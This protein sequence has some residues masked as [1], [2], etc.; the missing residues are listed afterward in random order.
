MEGLKR[1]AKG[2]GAYLLPVLS[3]YIYASKLFAE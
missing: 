2:I 3:R 1:E